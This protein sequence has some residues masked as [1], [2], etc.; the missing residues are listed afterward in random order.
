MSVD[1]SPLQVIGQ[2]DVQLE[3]GGKGLA[4]RV[5]VAD[6]VT[7]EAILGLDVLKEHCTI[8]DLNH[9]RVHLD[10]KEAPL[11]LFMQQDKKRNN[12]D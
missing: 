3:I 9:Q 12:H 10:D 7:T 6:S 8:I 4:T 11:R 2:A 5:V 1:R